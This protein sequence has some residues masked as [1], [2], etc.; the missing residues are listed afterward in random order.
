MYNCG[1]N[2][3]KR[4]ISIETAPRPIRYNSEYSM[5]LLLLQIEGTSGDFKFSNSELFWMNSFDYHFL[6]YILLI[7]NELKYDI[8]VIFIKIFTGFI[9]VFFTFGCFLW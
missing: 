5:L 1:Q 3:H 4:V 8:F 7:L 9:L 2:N 6:L